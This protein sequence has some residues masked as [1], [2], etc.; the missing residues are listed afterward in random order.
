MNSLDSQ[1]NQKSR[2]QN[3]TCYV[4]AKR[5]ETFLKNKY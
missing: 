2:F 4:E 5:I 1:Y 3:I